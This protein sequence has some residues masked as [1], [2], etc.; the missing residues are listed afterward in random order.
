VTSSTEGAIGNDTDP[1][2]V[3]DAESLPKNEPTSKYW[4]EDLPEKRR[5]KPN[6][7]YVQQ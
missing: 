5:R 1:E 2:I 6:L 4:D 7:K 3:P